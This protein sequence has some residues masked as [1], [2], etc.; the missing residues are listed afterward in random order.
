MLEFMVI[1]KHLVAVGVFRAT[2][3]ATYSPAQ[4]QEF[5]NRR[6]GTH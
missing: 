4:M 3:A 6:E 5:S 1:R 2:V